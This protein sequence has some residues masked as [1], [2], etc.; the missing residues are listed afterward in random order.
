MNDSQLW[1][2]RADDLASHGGRG[3]E[4]ERLL[5]DAIA[6]GHRPA[7]VR[8]AEFLWHES[9]RDWQDVIMEVEELLSR[10][11]DD[12]VPGAANAFG[13]VL[14]DIE[15]DHRAEAMFRRALADGDPAAATNLAFMLHGRGADMA[16]YDVLVSAARNGDDL[17]YQ[18]LG[19][20][21]D[22]AEPVW[23]EITDAWSAARSRDEPPS[24]FCYLRG[25][26]DL[27]LTAG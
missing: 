2:H 14:A 24:L 13:N 7:L 9:G 18:I 6:A 1:F 10:A 21:I 11:V 20:N 25:S 26:W 16:A 17:A 23:T 22:P 3:G 27:D 12:D 19:H 15:E 4:A 5:R 8:L